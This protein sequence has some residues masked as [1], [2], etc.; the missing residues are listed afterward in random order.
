M[1]AARMRRRSL[2]EGD[3]NLRSTASDNVKVD[4]KLMKSGFVVVFQ[5]DKDIIPMA[6]VEAQVEILIMRACKTKPLS[7]ADIVLALGHKQ[8]S[9]NFT[10]ARVGRSPA[11]SLSPPPPTSSS[12]ATQERGVNGRVNWKSVGNR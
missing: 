6:Q 12:N 5:R 3:K 2:R 4:Y 8:L 10:I 7:S 1:I 11:V 9:G